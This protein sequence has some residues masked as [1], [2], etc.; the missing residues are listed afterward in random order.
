MRTWIH[1]SAAPLSGALAALMLLSGCTV[2]PRYHPPSDAAPARY[3]ELPAADAAATATGADAP[4]PAAPALAGSPG[5]KPAQPQDDAIRGNWWELF[6]DPQLNALEVRVNV[7]NQTIASAF[8]A[9]QEART[10]VSQARSQYYPTLT[11]SPGVTRSRQPPGTASGATTSG[12]TTGT[13]VS[14]G[15]TQYTDFS[16]P[17]DASWTP[18]LW[19]RVRNTVKGNVAAAQA[20][21]A[22]L[23][24]TRLTAQAE[25]A[26][27][28]YELR[29]QDALV[30]LLGATVAAY[31]Q[32]LT[33]T[34]ALYETGIDDDE[35][36][37]QAQVQLQL[38]QAQATNLAIARAQ[39]EHA[40][41]L[42]VGQ[43]PS[44][45]SIAAEPGPLL[46][47]L[48]AVP[49]SIP[50]Q[51]LERRPDIA[52]SER[53]M[54]QANA[55]IGVAT[56]AYYPTLTL[57]AAA[58][59]ESSSLS[60]WLTWPYRF[61]SVGST[62]SETLFSAGLRRAT[63]QQYQAAYDETV[64]NYRQTVLT[65]FGQVED[66][67]AA[68]R[69]LA[70]EIQ[71]QDQ[72]VNSAQRLLG[73]AT[74]R[75][76]L[77]LDPYLDVITAQTTLLSAQQTAVTLRLQQLTADVQLIEALGGGWDASQLP[78]S[79]DVASTSPLHP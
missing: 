71:Q 49:V 79:K 27:D 21:A 62:L 44:T 69:I 66:N 61:W 12:A 59:F 32:S 56:S 15:G 7:S 23:A 26:V 50:S 43:P 29:A 31:Q 17:F 70:S 74:D 28:Y 48:P 73:I 20:S 19:G 57:T 72:A 77:G 22:D 30:Q 65:A 45:F 78:A 36:V 35:S 38:T 34:Q 14:S 25:L 60:K 18:D 13:L 63:V 39:Y 4:A 24:N 67:L 11:V 58:G 46:V 41:A 33:L 1:A 9:F 2:G 64:A 37:A 54:A 52:A 6:G 3:K 68:L 75:Y 76:R 55:Q 47:A 16:L 42:L 53:L 40:I 10:L 51:L 8:A 5:W